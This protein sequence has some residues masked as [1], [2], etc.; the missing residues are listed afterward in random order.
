MTLMPTSN[1]SSLPSTEVSVRPSSLSGNLYHDQYT[2]DEFTHPKS[3]IEVVGTVDKGE[4]EDEI[5]ELNTTTV[6]SHTIPGV[7][8]GSPIE[9]TIRANPAGKLR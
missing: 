7:A 4:D 3:D 8:S 6:G 1:L 2:A 5:E 9:C